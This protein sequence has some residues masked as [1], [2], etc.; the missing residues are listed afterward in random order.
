MLVSVFP[1]KPGY[2]M[3]T[4]PDCPTLG[5]PSRCYFTALYTTAPHSTLLPCTQECPASLGC[6]PSYRSLDTRKYW[7]FFPVNLSGFLHTPSPT[8]IGYCFPQGL[9][10]GHL[11]YTLFGYIRFLMEKMVRGLS[12]SQ[13]VNGGSV[14]RFLGPSVR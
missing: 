6:L 8:S 3:A 2:Q 9:T 5:D 10:V 4:Q 14:R 7:H 13:A 11:I 12:P 1:L